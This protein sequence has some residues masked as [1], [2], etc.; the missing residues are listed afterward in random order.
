[1]KTFKEYV[2]ELV[3]MLEDEPELGECG[4][5]YAADDEGNAFHPLDFPPTITYTTDSEEYYIETIHED[6]IAE[7]EEDGVEL[8]KLVCINQGEAR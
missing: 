8:T 3:K 2:A 4:V 5:I 6:D 1:M 7:Y